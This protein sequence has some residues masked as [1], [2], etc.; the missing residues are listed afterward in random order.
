MIVD[1]FRAAF[2]AGAAAI[3]LLTLGFIMNNSGRFEHTIN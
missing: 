1:A 2:L 3:M